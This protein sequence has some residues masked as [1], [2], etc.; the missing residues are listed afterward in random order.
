[1]HELLISPIPEFWLVRPESGPGH[2]WVV[3][4]RGTLFVSQSAVNIVDYFERRGEKI[5][6]STIYR[7]RN[8]RKVKG[9][10]ELNEALY[11]LEEAMF[12]VRDCEK[13]L[14]VNHATVDSG[15]GCGE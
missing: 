15:P 14:V 12:L 9:V 7:A 8:C 6:I 3:H 13:W 4:V 2:I 11:G 10:D 1:M 5:C